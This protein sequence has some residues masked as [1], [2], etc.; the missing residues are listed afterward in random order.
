MW[1]SWCPDGCTLHT[2]PFVPDRCAAVG[3]WD[4]AASATIELVRW[5][6]E[7]LLLLLATGCGAFSAEATP[8]T[9]LPDADVADGAA[10]PDAGGSESG[11]EIDGGVRTCT[12]VT[13]FTDDFERQNGMI[14]GSWTKMTTVNATLSLDG[15]LPLAG[16]KSLKVDVGSGTPPRT[17]LL[18]LALAADA[19]SVDASFWLRPQTLTG[20][21]S[22]VRV[23]YA[24]S[25]VDLRWE[26]GVLSVV[27]SSDAGKSTKTR[28]DTLTDGTVKA[29]ELHVDLA[30]GAAGE[31]AFAIGPTNGMPTTTRS[32]PLAFPHGDT[33]SLELGAVDIGDG[34]PF[35]YFLDHFALK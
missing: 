4:D 28:L 32:V 22:V 5:N 25:R 30:A 6:G 11:V 24:G 23:A 2:A 18:E 33:Q 15:V 3:R 7:A 20:S 21:A 16:T 13:A 34:T 9:S 27:E 12:P 17:A 8:A 1:F 10:L 35:A 26:S 14:Q 31:V 19:C 29:I